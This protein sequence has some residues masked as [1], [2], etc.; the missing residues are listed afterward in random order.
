[1][2]NGYQIIKAPDKR[3][4]TVCS[5]VDSIPN[6]CVAKMIELMDQYNGCGLSAPQVG[7][8][9]RFFIM[10]LHGRVQLMMNPRMLPL[11]L[12]QKLVIKDE[13]CLSIPGVVVP[14]RR[15]FRIDAIWESY[16]PS[17][18]V[19]EVNTQMFGDDARIF[20]HELDHLNGVLITDKLAEQYRWSER[21]VYRRGEAK[22][23]DDCPPECE[24]ARHRSPDLGTTDSD[25]PTGHD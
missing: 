3:L 4:N 12:G 19:N 21:R 7:I 8:L 11:S 2:D 20:Q 23:G 13:G 10:R 14:V 5:T 17:G 9:A 22:T 6:E 25:K 16:L 24:E 15:F 18:L 1:M